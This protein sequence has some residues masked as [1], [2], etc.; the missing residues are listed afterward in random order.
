MTGN[1]GCSGLFAVLT[2][3]PAAGPFAA[4]VPMLALLALAPLALWGSDVYKL[5][6]MGLAAAGVFG[7]L[8]AWNAHQHLQKDLSALCHAVKPIALN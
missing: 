1:T 3:F 7:L 2:I 5:A 8:A 6:L 4:L